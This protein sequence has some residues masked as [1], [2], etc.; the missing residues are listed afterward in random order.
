M[1]SSYLTENIAFIVKT[2]WLMLL[3]EIMAL[4]CGNH[5]RHT[6]T[7]WYNAVFFQLFK[8]VV[9]NDQYSAFESLC[10]MPGVSLVEQHDLL[11]AS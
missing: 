7:I 10:Q 1:L 5:T 11:L 9:H 6:R 2:S 8:G 3:G 4:Y